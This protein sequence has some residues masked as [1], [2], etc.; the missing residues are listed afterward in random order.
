MLSE[1]AHV[2]VDSLIIFL[3]EKVSLLS[4][5]FLGKVCFIISYKKKRE[6]EVCMQVYNI[7]ISSNYKIK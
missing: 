3:N 6:N 1:E 5:I 7:Q 4:L 2:I